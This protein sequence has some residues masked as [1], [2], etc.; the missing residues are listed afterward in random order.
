[1][2]LTR[3]E[4]DEADE[5]VVA[6]GTK[7]GEADVGDDVGDSAVDEETVNG[8]VSGADGIE[9][10]KRKGD[11]VE[12][13]EV[14][15]VCVIVLVGGTES[16]EAM[17]DGDCGTG[18][19]VDGLEELEEL[20]AE[21]GGGGSKSVLRKTKCQKKSILRRT[22]YLHVYRIVKENGP[23][24]EQDRPDHRVKALLQAL[25]SEGRLIVLEVT[26]FRSNGV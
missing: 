10:E 22:V 20:V 6:D 18:C 4:C 7:E 25:L 12:L 26:V 11:N 13:V 21:L 3:S 15:V 16:D 9:K 23:V 17:V 24:A 1:M 14:E 2:I 8:E 5:G 19:V